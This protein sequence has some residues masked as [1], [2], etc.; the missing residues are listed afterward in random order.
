MASRGRSPLNMVFRL[1]ACSTGVNLGGGAGSAVR[2]TG[3]TGWVRT[4]MALWQD[5]RRTRQN[6]VCYWWSRRDDTGYLEP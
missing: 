3:D 2:K 6:G 5:G 4:L 1:D